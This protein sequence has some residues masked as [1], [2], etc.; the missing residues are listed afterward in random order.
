MLKSRGHE[1]GVETDAE[2][3]VDRIRVAI[4]KELEMLTNDR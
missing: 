4:C 3:T 2:K 1:A